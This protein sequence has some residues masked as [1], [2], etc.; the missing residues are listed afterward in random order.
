VC[1]LVSRIDFSRTRES[2][3]CNVFSSFDWMLGKK[4]P[5]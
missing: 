3:A 4:C 2:M 1:V 5:N